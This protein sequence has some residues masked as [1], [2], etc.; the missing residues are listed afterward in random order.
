MINLSS[1]IGLFTGRQTVASIYWLGFVL[2]NV[3]LGVS[4]RVINTL[5]ITADTDVSLARVEIIH[6]L[7][8]I[9]VFAYFAIIARSI[10]IAGFTERRPGFWGWVAI[11]LIWFGAANAGHTALTLM[12]PNLPTP[13]FLAMIEIR[14]FDEQLPQ[15][16]PDGSVLKQVK[17][18]NGSLYYIIESDDVLPAELTEY[19][20]ASMSLDDTYSQDLCRDFEGYFRGGLRQIVYVEGYRN[21]TVESYLS[22]AKCLDWIKQN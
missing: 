20:E 10:W 4:N 1:V 7:C 11:V 14:E 13:L 21:Q 9:V 8:A 12:F 3:L 2:A 15:Q 16:M 6:L 17:I 18:E 19:W 5:Y 22:G